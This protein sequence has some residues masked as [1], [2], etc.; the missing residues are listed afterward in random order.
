MI[1]YFILGIL[2]WQ[3]VTF[4]YMAIT[5]NEDKGVILGSFFWWLISSVALTIFV[6]G[7]KFDYRKFDSKRLYRKWKK[8][9]KKPN[10]DFETFIS[11]NGKHL[12][13]SF[14]DLIKLKEF[15]EFEKKA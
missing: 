1:I 10:Y 13:N 7:F 3:L 11:I 6:K 15:Q 2:F 8:A 9:I 12:N 14:N 4:I 5:K